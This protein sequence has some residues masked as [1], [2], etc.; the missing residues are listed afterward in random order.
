MVGACSK[1]GREK[2][3]YRLFEGKPDGKRTLTGPRSKW[4]DNIRMDLGEIG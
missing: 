3:A 1:N 2:E 4:V